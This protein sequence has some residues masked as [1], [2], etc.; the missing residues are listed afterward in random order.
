MAQQ[1]VPGRPGAR[2]PFP[3]HYLQ[4]GF[5]S[6]TQASVVVWKGPSPSGEALELKLK[7]LNHPGALKMCLSGAGRDQSLRGLSWLSLA[8][9]GWNLAPHTYQACTLLLSNPQPG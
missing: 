9:Q 1:H 7:K 4:H 5:P 3:F 2:T 6:T 8:M